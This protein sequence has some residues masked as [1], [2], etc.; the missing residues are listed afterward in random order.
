[1]HPRNA[2]G[3]REI[4]MKHAVAIELIHHGQTDQMKITANGEYY[5]VMPLGYLRYSEHDEQ[6]GETTTTIRLLPD[7]LRIQRRGGI[8]SQLTLKPA[9]RTAVQYRMGGLNLLLTA[10]TKQL[11]FHWTGC[12]GNIICHYE[13]WE[14]DERLDS[15]RLTLNV[16]LI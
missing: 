7:E 8:E 16:S 3:I 9:E 11:E 15:I 6:N 5:E 13:L 4:K 10:Y 1:M 12:E 2:V 14:Q